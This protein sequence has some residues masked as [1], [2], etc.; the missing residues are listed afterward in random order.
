[1]VVSFEEPWAKW[2]SEVV[3]NSKIF[4]DLMQLEEIYEK[5]TENAK[6]ENH[7]ETSS[8]DEITK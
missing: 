8:K 4:R 7:F 1:M 3:S 6:R 2:D 5:L